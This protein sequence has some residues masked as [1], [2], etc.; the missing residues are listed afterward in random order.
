MKQQFVITHRYTI[1]MEI[2]KLNLFSVDGHLKMCFN[3]NI[4]ISDI[5]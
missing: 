1:L 2:D 4:R 3:E 5:Y